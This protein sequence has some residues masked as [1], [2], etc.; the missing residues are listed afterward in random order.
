MHIPWRTSVDVF[1]QILRRHGVEQDSVT[2]VEAAWVGF[3]EFLQLDIDGIDSTPDS[4]ADG[5]I[6]QWGRRSW[7]DNRLI[8]TFT[9]QLAIADVGDHDDPYW[10]PELWQLDFEMAFD[11]E[12]DLIGL[13]NL[14]VHDTGFRFPPTGPLRTAA[15]ADTWAETQRHAPVRAAWIATPA[16]SGLFFECVC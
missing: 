1:A 9:R 5:F 3:T 2:D 11:D 15:L 16:S 12:P 13:D 8:L 4:D 10:Q 6:I 14:D 7:S